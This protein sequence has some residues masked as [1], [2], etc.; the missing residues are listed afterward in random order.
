MWR[1]RDLQLRI[2]TV[3]LAALLVPALSTATS[4]NDLA[5]TFLITQPDT[6]SVVS[7]ADPHT[8]LR[9]AQLLEQTGQL[10]E[11][12]SQY[13]HAIGALSQKHGK[14]HPI[15]RSAVGSYTI[16]L[17]KLQQAG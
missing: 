16:C 3:A 2:Q 5:F 7:S 9:S 15:V 11:A 13:Q 10:S 17:T 4:Q 8:T 12:I 1:G 14:S 6:V